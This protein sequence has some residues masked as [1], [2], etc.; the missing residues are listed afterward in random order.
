MHDDDAN[1]GGDRGGDANGDGDG[2]CKE[3]I[4][5]LF[6][7][8]LPIDRSWRLLP[9]LP[10]LLLPAE[11]TRGAISSKMDCSYFDW[12]GGLKDRVKS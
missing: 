9:G 11:G 5:Q 8:K 2:D 10:I 12:R 4:P 3:K 1:G 7:S 6:V